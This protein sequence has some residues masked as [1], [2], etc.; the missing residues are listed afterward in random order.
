MVRS[1]RETAHGSQHGRSS[2]HAGDSI[3]LTSTHVRVLL[4]FPLPA[5][6][7]IINADDVVTLGGKFFVSVISA[8]AG[9][10]VQSAACASAL[11]SHTPACL[12]LLA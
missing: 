11:P 4:L 6:R 12:L 1:G 3:G 2:R 7:H 9:C 5:C 8:I 10:R